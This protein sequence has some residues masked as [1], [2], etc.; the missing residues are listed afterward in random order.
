M[1]GLTA[2]Q[3]A[4][5]ELLD[6]HQLHRGHA[7]IL[8]VRYL[9]DQA[10]ICPRKSDAGAGMDGVAAHMKLVDDGRLPGVAERLVAL[11]VEIRVG[12][13]ALRR[14]GGVIDLGQ[15]QVFLR[16]RR[17]RSREPVESRE[18]GECAIAVA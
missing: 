15:G 7:E 17:D 14:G 6:R 8:Q 3:L 11:P 13:D 1:C 10:A 18:P 5:V 9:L 2:R 16:A 4:L 12:D